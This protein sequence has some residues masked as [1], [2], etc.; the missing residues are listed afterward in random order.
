[1]KVINSIL[2]SLAC[3]LNA[4]IH[5]G[6]SPRTSDSSP[7]KMSEASVDKDP[8]QTL[9]DRLIDIEMQ[10][11]S[12]KALFTLGHLVPLTCGHNG[13]PH[14]MELEILKHHLKNSNLLKS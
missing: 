6:A 2:K 3:N 13:I 14:Y 10:G 11:A 4:K 1:M 5:Y 12:Q 9:G 8:A 7:V